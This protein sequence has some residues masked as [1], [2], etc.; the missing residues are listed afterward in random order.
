MVQKS[1]WT[2]ISI[3]KDDIAR[4]KRLLNHRVWKLKKIEGI[5]NSTQFVNNALEKELNLHESIEKSFDAQELNQY[6]K[7][8]KTEL[9]KEQGI[10]NYY[11]FLNYMMYK[12]K[13]DDDFKRYLESESHTRNLK[14]KLKEYHLV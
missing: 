2:K 1:D 7:L 8:K 5:K 10:D 3:R 4:I 11:E 14:K 6:Y 9:K 13:D 12:A